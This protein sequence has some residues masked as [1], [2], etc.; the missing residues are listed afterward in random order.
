MLVSKFAQEQFLI[1]N[2]HKTYLQKDSP[3]EFSSLTNM[4]E[5]DKI[6][7]VKEYGYTGGRYGM[8]NHLNIMKEIKEEG[9]VVLSFSPDDTF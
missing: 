4:D 5:F 8:S 6:I 1:E 9:P 3:C 2:K 7:K